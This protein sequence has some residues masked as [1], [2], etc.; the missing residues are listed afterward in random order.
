MKAAE[1]A[2]W[3]RTAS[4]VLRGEE[5]VSR[6]LSQKTK[7]HLKATMFRL[8]ERAMF[9]ELIDLQRNP[10]EL[11]EV[12]GISKRKKRPSILTVEQCQ[13]ICAALPDPYSTMFT[14]A[15]CLGLRVNEILALKWSD[16]D[17]EKGTV[18]V[19]R[20]V[21]HGR[22]SGVK[23]EYSEDDLPI[24]PKFAALLLEWRKECPETDDG[25]VFPNPSTGKPY[26]AETIQQ[27][28]LRPVGRTLGLNHSLGWHA[29][30]H[31]YRS[32]LDD[33]GAPIGVQQKLM[34]HAQISTTMDVYGSAYL[35]AKRVANG[36][37]VDR[38]LPQKDNSQTLSM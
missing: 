32:L 23:T 20:G 26:H 6:P 24:H 4:S 31:S 10:M 15:V 3:L 14:V 11:V 18:L 25:W 30:R 34:R 36:A 22:I 37:I 12:R 16:F 28:Y 33:S 19:Q 2:D 38:F 27:D 9:W 35:E 13:K 7:G 5:K 17:F 1:I 21:V 8:F 29:A